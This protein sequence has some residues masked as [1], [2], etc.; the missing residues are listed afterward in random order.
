VSQSQLIPVPPRTARPFL[1]LF[2]YTFDSGQPI[3]YQTQYGTPASQ[4]YVLS[5]AIGETAFTWLQ[6]Y[7]APVAYVQ[8]NITALTPGVHVS[9]VPAA[10]S[11]RASLGNIVT[12]AGERAPSG[13]KLEPLTFH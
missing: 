1:G 4:P 8:T 3:A 9:P 12:L 11:H 7:R 2:G 5:H 10:S 13:W 6:L